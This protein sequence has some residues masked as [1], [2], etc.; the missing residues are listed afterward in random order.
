MGRSQRGLSA[1]TPRRMTNPAPSRW[2]G[3]PNCFFT[4]RSQLAWFKA[5]S[6]QFGHEGVYL[7][8]FCGAQGHERAFR[9]FPDI[10]AANV[11]TGV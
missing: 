9:C 8:N 11:A 2:R 10:A 5:Q 1:P 6:S 4:C 7:F 3:A